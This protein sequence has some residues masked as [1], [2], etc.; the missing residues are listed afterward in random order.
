[1][2]TDETHHK[3]ISTPTLPNHNFNQHA[4]FTLI[5]KLV[6]VNIDKGLPIL[7]LKK[8]EGLYVE[9]LRN[10]KSGWLQC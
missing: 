7:Q 8:L 5:Q 10:C 9:N 2:L 3:Q 6:K 4:R 1:M